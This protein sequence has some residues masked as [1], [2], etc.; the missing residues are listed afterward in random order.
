MRACRRE[1]AAC[2]GLS[3]GAALPR[4]AA[5]RAGARRAT[6]VRTPGVALEHP[7]VA[8]HQELREMG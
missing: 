4:T 3:S 8:A 5:A 1:Q 7:A 6:P 2:G